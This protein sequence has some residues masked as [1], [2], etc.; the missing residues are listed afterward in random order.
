M[1]RL[2]STFAIELIDVDNTLGAATGLTHANLG[3]IELFEPFWFV[4]ADPL[5]APIET[6][7]WAH[8]KLQYQ[9]V[10]KVM[11]LSDTLYRYFPLISKVYWRRAEGGG[12]G[13]GAAARIWANAT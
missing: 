2:G 3:E 10:G 9:A 12:T 13:N 8:A 7:C 5:A 1:L 4:H 11:G 6:F